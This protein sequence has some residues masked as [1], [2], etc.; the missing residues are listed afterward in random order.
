MT[1]VVLV[2]L[3]AALS[4]SDMAHNMKYGEVTTN[5]VTVTVTTRMEKAVVLDDDGVTR[6]FMIDAYE[7]D[8]PAGCKCTYVHPDGKCV[9][10]DMYLKRH[11][12]YLKRDALREKWMREEMERQRNPERQYPSLL[13]RRLLRGY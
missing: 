5:A 2:A 7:L 3:G 10:W 6:E 11:E 9:Y 4:F 12:I 8:P 1:N 13:R